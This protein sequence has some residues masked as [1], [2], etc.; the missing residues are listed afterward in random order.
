MG[1]SSWVR[2]LDQAR[3]LTRRWRTCD[4]SGQEIAIGAALSGDQALLAAVETGRPAHVLRQ[5]GGAGAAGRHQGQPT[6]MSVICPRR[7]F[8]PSITVMQPPNLA[9]RMGKSEIEARELLKRLQELF[10]M[11]VEWAEAN[12]HAGQLRGYLSTVFGWT[13]I[14]GGERPNTLRNFVVQANAAEMLRLACCLTTEHGIAVCGPL[15]DALMVQG[16]ID[17]IDDVVAAVR[18]STWRPRRDRCSTGWRLA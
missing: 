1:P 11:F 5:S 18:V 6:D 4:Y 9:L 8:T 13:L 17:E 3:V 7:A 12:V 14:T 15:H 16:P 10:P 2:G